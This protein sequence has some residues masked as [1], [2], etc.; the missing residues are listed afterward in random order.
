MRT[1]IL[2]II[3]IIIITTTT[4]TITVTIK[5]NR[6]YKFNYIMILNII[7]FLKTTPFKTNRNFK[8]VCIEFLFNFTCVNTHNEASNKQREKRVKSRT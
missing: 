8:T 5:L 7:F 4:T 3:T 6:T 1:S 2:I